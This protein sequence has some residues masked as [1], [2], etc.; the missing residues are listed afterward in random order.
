VICLKELKI[1][2]QWAMPNS[3][4]F[5]IEPLKQVIIKHSS[6]TVLDPFSNDGIIQYSIPNCKYIGNDI[7]PEMNTEYHMDAT[8][9]LKIFDDCSVDTVLYDPPYTPRQVKEC[10]DGFGLDITQEETQASFWSK[11][12]DEIARVLKVGGKCLSFCWNTNGIGLNRGFEIVEIV[13]VAH[14]GSKNDTIC[15]VERKLQHQTSMEL[16]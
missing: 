1:S 16:D 13:L 6:G 14:G 12:K 10:Y 11:H 15:T 3:L 9:F 2:R 5:R 7:N 8:D 4:T